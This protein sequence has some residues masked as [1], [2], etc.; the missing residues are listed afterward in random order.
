ML[1]KELG[2]IGRR[3]G[4]RLILQIL[5]VLSVSYQACAAST[6][7]PEPVV[8]SQDITVT[9]KLSEHL[10]IGETTLT[11]AAGTHRVSL[12]LSPTARIASVTISGAKIPF[13]FAKGAISLDFPEKA[14]HEAIP[15]TVTYRAAFNDPL[16]Q[17]PGS[18][19]DPTYGVHGVITAQGTFLGDGAGWYPTPSSLPQKRS[20]RISAPAGTEAIT[21]GRRIS[22]KVAGAVWH[23]SWEELHP[24]GGLSLC[25]GP[26]LVEERRVGGVD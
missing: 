1:D 21:A 19:E 7:W 20:I 11:F 2:R 24:V 14:G 15:V 6:A 12:M 26:Y 18:S 9:L 23:S 4:I 8:Q 17:Q 3:R 5:F 10:L 13:S 16:P 25:A 22:R